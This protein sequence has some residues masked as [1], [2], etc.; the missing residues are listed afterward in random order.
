MERG[1]ANVYSK[2][3]NHPDLHALLTLLAPA[4]KSFFA[5]LIYLPQ[6]PNLPSM[7]REVQV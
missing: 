3:G 2:A 5:T 6:F 7:P 4:N 1:S